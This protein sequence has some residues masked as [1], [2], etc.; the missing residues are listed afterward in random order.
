MACWANL[1]AFFNVTEAGGDTRIDVDFNGAADSAAFDTQLTIVLD[2]LTTGLSEEDLLNL[3]LGN[4]QL[5][6]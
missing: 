1:N 6:V 3:L 5:V 2:S 4:N